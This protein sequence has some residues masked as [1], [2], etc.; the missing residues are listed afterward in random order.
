[1]Q[2]EVL[3][4]ILF[5]LY[6][7]DCEMDFINS[8]SIPFEVR[9]L[10]LFLLMYADDMVIFSETVSGLQEMLD[11]LFLYTSKW[12]LSVNISKTKIVVFRN[13]GDI[14]RMRNGITITR[15]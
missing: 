7:N 12:S 6:V 8:D 4:P 14:K 2:G 9:E 13:G 10:N 15:N 1:M 3:S 5:H 11:T